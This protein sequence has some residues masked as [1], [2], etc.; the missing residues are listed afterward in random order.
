MRK[1]LLL[2]LAAPLFVACETGGGT[3][4]SP[5]NA[6]QGN[7]DRALRAAQPG[8]GQNAGSGAA[9]V[10]GVMDDGSNPTI[11][12]GPAPPGSG[13]GCPPGTRLVVTNTTRADSR[14]TTECR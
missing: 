13:L 6:N 2:A 12:R 8:S 4:V 7:P 5:F 9:R 10:T 1:I 14:P 11:E 3:G